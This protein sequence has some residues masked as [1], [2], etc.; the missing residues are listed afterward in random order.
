ME[1][2]NGFVTAGSAKPADADR[3]VALVWR[4]MLPKNFYSLPYRQS[5]MLALQYLPLEHIARL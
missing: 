5:Y 4:I 1:S 2:S 3:G